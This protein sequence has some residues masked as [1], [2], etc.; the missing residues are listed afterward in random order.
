MAAVFKRNVWFLLLASIAIFTVG[1]LGGGG[2]SDLVTHTLEVNI[3]GEG[4]VTPA[5]TTHKVS[6]QATFELEA[7]PAESWEFKH[8]VL[9]DGQKSTEAKITIPMDKNKQATA[10]FKQTV[11]VIPIGEPQGYELAIEV[12]GDGFVKPHVGAAMFAENEEVELEATPGEDCTFEKWIIVSAIGTEEI[13]D[14]KITI[15][16]D[17]DKQIT[18]VFSRAECEVHGL[19]NT[20]TIKKEG[21]GNITPLNIGT[22]ELQPNQRYS[23]TAVP[24][25][26]WEFD[27]WIIEDKASHN[28]YNSREIRVN[29][30]EDKTATA[31]FRKSQNSKETR[32]LTVNVI[33]KGTLNYEPGQHEIRHKREIRLNAEPAPGWKVFSFNQ[34]AAGWEGTTYHLDSLRIQMNFDTEITVVFADQLSHVY[35][36]AEYILDSRPS[37]DAA[38]YATNQTRSQHKIAGPYIPGFEVELET[39]THRGGTNSREQ[40]H[41]EFRGWVIR[42]RETGEELP[43]EKYLADPKA[44]ETVLTMPAEDVTVTAEWV[45]FFRRFPNESYSTGIQNVEDDI[46]KH[47]FDLSALDDGDQLTFQF[48]ADEYPSRYQ[49]F[50]GTW[51]SVITE[52][53]GTL[54]FDTHWVSSNPNFYKDKY[55]DLKLPDWHEKVTRKNISPYATGS[56]G[57]YKDLITK[58]AGLDYVLIIVYNKNGRY[59]LNRS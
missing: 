52:Q 2:A 6:D 15:K 59:I 1:C 32:T 12:Q 3:L 23:L 5:G 43:A 31:V 53:Q 37:Q 39:Y 18:A 8:W 55:E 57:V 19:T 25:T 4:T 38:I 44:K 41:D 49:V 14:P 24:N 35:P 7:K 11:Q 34:K 20:L 27:K 45:R 36:E 26:G 17:D 47:Y 28:I 42:S 16:M 33:G 58:R 40:A 51:D 46:T 10:V 56:G 21:E 13:I 48:S 9:E 54:I 29:L 30:D 22:H 50:Y